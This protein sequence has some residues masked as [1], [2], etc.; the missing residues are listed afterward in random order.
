MFK[1]N[2]LENFEEG[3][4][5][6]AFIETTRWRGIKIRLEGRN[7]T[8]YL[9]VRDRLAFTG[10]RDLTPVDERNLRLRKPNRIFTISFS[11]NF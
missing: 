3:V 6:N 8:N 11:G 1:V 7:L 9:E 2:E 5:L 4:E 10:R